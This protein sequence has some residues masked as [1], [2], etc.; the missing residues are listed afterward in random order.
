MLVRFLLYQCENAAKPLRQKEPEL[1]PR[2][3]AELNTT[4]AGYNLF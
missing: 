4:F 1:R 3:T 2:L